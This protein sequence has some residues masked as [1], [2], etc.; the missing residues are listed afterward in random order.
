M[1][2]EKVTQVQTEIAED[3]R[4]D[5]QKTIFHDLITDDQLRPEEKTTDRLEGEGVG[6]VGAG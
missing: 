6:L 5:K 3:T 2:H 4:I 1:V